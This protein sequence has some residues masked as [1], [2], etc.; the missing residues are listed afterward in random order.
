MTPKYDDRFLVYLIDEATKLLGYMEHNY[1]RSAGMD[2]QSHVRKGLTSI[3]IGAKD[4]LNR[5]EIP[6]PG[7]PEHVTGRIKILEDQVEALT[8]KL[9]IVI[10][11]SCAPSTQHR[12][13]ENDKNS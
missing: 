3:L 12:I 11:Y 2:A 5:V 4:R 6:K 7:C 9:N 8:A 10:N 13:K 1:P